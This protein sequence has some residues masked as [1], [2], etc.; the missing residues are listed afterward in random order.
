MIDRSFNRAE[1]QKTLGKAADRQP[2]S[3]AQACLSNADTPQ[4]EGLTPTCSPQ[5][6]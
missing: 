6:L 2:P 5:H 4:Q 3:R 1:L